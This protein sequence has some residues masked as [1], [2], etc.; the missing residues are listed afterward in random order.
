MFKKFQLSFEKN[1]F[2]I[3]IE[4]EHI[5]NGRKGVILVDVKNDLVP[6][7]RSTT[8]YT[9]PPQAFTCDVKT[10]R[11]NIRNNSFN[12]AMVEMYDS[13][14]KTM[15]YHSDQALDLE[16][17]SD[18]AIYS[19]YKDPSRPSRKLVIRN[20]E[21][22]EIIEL[23]MEHN[24]VIMFSVLTNSLYEHKIVLIDSTTTEWLGIT[25]RQ[26]KTF[27]KFVDE[28]PYFCTNV[29]LSLVND[30]MLSLANDVQEKEF[31]KIIQ[32]INRTNNF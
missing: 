9:N 1:M 23:V 3:P 17:T 28:V 14:Y 5:T 22:S 12:N 25:F 24:S 20:K 4:F 2:H 11:D 13:S 15:R 10:I 30:V 18:I 8:R 32:F 6:L 31:F 19:C 21:T 7:V 29:M 16:P 27:I 26:S